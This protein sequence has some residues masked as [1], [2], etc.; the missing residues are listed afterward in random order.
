MTGRGCGVK[1]R[2]KSRARR[3]RL[4][5]YEAHDAHD[6]RF[7]PFICPDDG[8]IDSQRMRQLVSLMFLD[9]L[10]VGICKVLILLALA[11]R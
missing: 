9:K 3:A 11:S 5:H 8:A 6:A 4:R 2:L 1:F 7:A 10:N